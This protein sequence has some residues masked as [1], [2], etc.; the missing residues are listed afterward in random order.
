M[1]EKHLAGDLA[2]YVGARRSIHVLNPTARFLWESLAEPL[3]FDELLYVL[4]EAFDGDPHT[5][6]TDLQQALDEFLQ[7]GIL[8]VR[9]S[10][11]EDPVA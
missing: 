10:G 9:E 11:D 6:R 7:L 5:L 1:K 4:T 2:L 3:T 8:H